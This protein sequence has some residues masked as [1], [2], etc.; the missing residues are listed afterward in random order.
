MHAGGENR[1]L[2]RYLDLVFFPQLRPGQCL[3]VCGPCYLE[4]N[5]AM[6]L[7]E[8]QDGAS[9]YFWKKQRN[10]DAS[11]P[12]GML[13]ELREKAQPGFPSRC[14]DAADQLKD[15]M[16]PPVSSRSLW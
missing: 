14:L 5:H 2:R 15:P 6:L 16:I 4:D 12:G 1:C 8:A 3:F 13:Q 7:L 9:Q 10:F 11:C